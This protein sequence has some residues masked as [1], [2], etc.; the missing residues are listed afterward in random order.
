MSSEQFP[1]ED[2]MVTAVTVKEG[3]ARVLA[4]TVVV[5]KP[6]GIVVNFE[7]PLPDRGQVLTL[8]Y[9]GAERVLRLRTRVVEVIGSSKVL[10][11]PEGPVTEG[12]RREFLRTL[13]TR[14]TTAARAK[15]GSQPPSPADLATAEAWPAQ[16][17]DLSGSGVSF[18]FNDVADMGETFSFSTVIDEPTPQVVSAVGDVVRCLPNDDG[19]HQVAIHFT[20]ISESDRDVVI[21]YVFRRYYEALAERLHGAS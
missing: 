9:G 14:P 2:Q 10:V 19:T 6:R 4:G 16:E 13:S 12:E 18:T 8:L 17:L 7:P 3:N 15:A 5:A 1:T 21:N 11:E 20:A